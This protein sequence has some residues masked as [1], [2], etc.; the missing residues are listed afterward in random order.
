MKKEIIEDVKNLK[1]QGA[2]VKVDEDQINDLI[3]K[4]FDKTY[5]KYTRKSYIESEIDKFLKDHGDKNISVNYSDGNNKIK[6]NT[7][8]I[9]K[10]LKN[11]II[12][13]LILTNLMKSI[14]NLGIMLQNLKNINLKLI[15]NFLKTK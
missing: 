11:Y 12:N 10:S 15:V 5:E 6:F 1:E 13:L 2:N 4:I 9:I 7:E 14:I 3:N 8:E